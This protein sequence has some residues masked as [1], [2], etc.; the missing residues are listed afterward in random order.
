MTAKEAAGATEKPVQT[1]L[2][3]AILLKRSP[4][5]GGFVRLASGEE[6]WLPKDWIEEDA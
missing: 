5:G 3:P 6:R 1:R 4:L 2:G